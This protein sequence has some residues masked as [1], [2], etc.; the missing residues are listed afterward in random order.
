[1][2]PPEFSISWAFVLEPTV[3]GG[4]RLIERFRL[5]GEMTGRAAAVSGRMLGLGIFTMARKQMLGIQ[6]PCRA[7][8]ARVDGVELVRD[9]DAVMQPTTDQP[10]SE[11]EIRVRVKVQ[12]LLATEPRA[13][14][15][16]ASSDHEVEPV[17]RLIPRS[18]SAPLHRS[19]R[20]ADRRDTMRSSEPVSIGRPYTRHDQSGPVRG[21][22]A[23][24]RDQPSHR[25]PPPEVVAPSRL[26]QRVRAVPPSGIRKFFDVIATMPDVISLGVGE[27]DFT[28]PPQIVEEG[29]RSLRAGRTHYTSNFGTH[30]A[31]PG[32]GGAPRAAATASTTTRTAS[33]SSRSAPRRRSPWPWPPSSIPA[34]RS[35]S[36]SRRTSPTCRPSSSPAARRCSC[37]TDR[38]DGF[39]LDPAAVEAAITPRTKALFLGYPCNPTGAVLPER[40][41]A[42]SPTSPRATTCSSSATR[43]T[44][45]SS[46]ATTAT[47]L[48]RAA[49]HARADDPAG[50]LLQGLRH[51]RLAR[52]LRVRA[53]GPAG[54]HRQG[55]PVP[56]HVRADDRPGRRPGGARAAPSRT[57]SR[58]VAE[59]DRRRRMFVDGLNR[60]GLPT[61]E[62]RGAFYAFPDI[63]GTGLTSESSASGCCSSSRSRSCPATPSARPA[64]ATCAPAGDQLRAARG[65]A[66]AHRALR[67]G[68][69]LAARPDARAG[70]TPG[71]PSDPPRATATRR[72]SASR[73][74]SS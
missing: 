34:T 19:R 64:R 51:D 74:T 57:S 5:S 10:P 6:T 32:A 56:D 13:A 17:K 73:S 60:I 36:T 11:P 2:T 68:P 21:H 1:M 23:D 67:R 26:A 31:A 46:T 16:P 66:G 44:T 29:V 42:P 63:A 8:G 59:Y 9:D 37:P 15:Q 4:T 24:H 33:S 12:E 45:A 70:L 38:D 72:S 69:R 35:S 25:P 47:G 14:R 62:P 20:P 53:Q 41:C 18:I 50:R 61:V 27:P 22:R 55:P 40:R 52:R 71:M 54:G 58:M 3:D 39:E 49:R 30:R 7:R 28:T 65:G 48:Q 43:S